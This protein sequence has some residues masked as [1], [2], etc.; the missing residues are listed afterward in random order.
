VFENFHTSRK[1]LQNLIIQLQVNNT[2]L[3][4]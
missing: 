4:G 1:L 2:W 3:F